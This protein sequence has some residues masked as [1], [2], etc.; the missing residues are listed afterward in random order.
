M[1]KLTQV[2]FSVKIRPKITFLAL[3]SAQVIRLIYFELLRDPD[4]LLYNANKITQTTGS[5]KY[6]SFWQTASYPLIILLS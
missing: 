1:P 2:S 6:L 5:K 3:T 4:I